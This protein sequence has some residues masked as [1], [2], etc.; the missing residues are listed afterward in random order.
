LNASYS[1]TREVFGREMT[2]TE[3]MEEIKKDIPFY[4]ESGGGVTFSGG[5]P[6]LQ[7]DFLNELLSA[8]KELGLHTTV[9][10]SGCVDWDI[11][12]KIYEKVDLFLYDLKLMDEDLHKKHTNASNKRILDNLR[13]LDRK[14]TNV[15]IRVPVVPGITDTKE[16]L[17]EIA[18]FVSSLKHIKK[19]NLLPYNPANEGKYERLD[20]VN[21]IGHLEIQ[22]DEEMKK[23]K[24]TFKP[25]RLNVSIG[26]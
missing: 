14:K 21:K 3:V 13:R 11:F 6:L 10:T 1:E 24:N 7:P 15:I 4:D 8:C 22:T 20:K 26:G 9:D 19:I 16:N 25:F 17:L 12:A 5:E 2:V 23:L 18:V